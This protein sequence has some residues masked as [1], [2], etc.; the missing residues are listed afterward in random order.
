MPIRT[1]QFNNRS[2]TTWLSLPLIS[3]TPNRLNMAAMDRCFSSKSKRIITFSRFDVRNWNHH[4]DLFIDGDLSKVK[5]TWCFWKYWKFS[6]EL[7]LFPKYEPPTFC[8][9]NFRWSNPILNSFLFPCLFVTLHQSYQKN[10]GQFTSHKSYPRTISFPRTIAFGTNHL[11]PGRSCEF[12]EM[13]WFNG[14]HLIQIQHGWCAY[15]DNTEWDGEVCLS[16]SLSLRIYIYTYVYIY[17][18][19]VIIDD[20]S[21]VKSF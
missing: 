9:S 6:Q 4:G 12:M 11:K 18:Y 2:T 7:I 8:N 3:H 14:T 15:I 16:L 10:Q 19:V 20:V 21:P 1:Q 5:I 17:I 13:L